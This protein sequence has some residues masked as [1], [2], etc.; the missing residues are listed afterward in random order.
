MKNPKEDCF[1]MG[2]ISV[3]FFVAYFP[4]V[5]HLCPK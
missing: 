1:F 4:T 5:P 3:D 2:Q